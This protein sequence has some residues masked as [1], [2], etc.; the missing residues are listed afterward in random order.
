M[1][2]IVA[3]LRRMTYGE[4]VGAAF[5]VN[6]MAVPERYKRKCLLVTTPPR[7]LI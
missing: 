2:G 1:R 5:N 4:I 6:S 7:M 3:L